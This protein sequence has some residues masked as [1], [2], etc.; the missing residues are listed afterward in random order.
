[1]RMPRQLYDM[2]VFIDGVSMMGENKSVTLP[3]LAEKL[4]EWQGAGMIAPV[5]LALGLEKLVLGHKYG[6]DIPQIERTFGDP[7]LD[8]AQIRFAGAFKNG[9]GYDDVQVVV[10]GR[11]TE[12]DRG[13]QSKGEKTEVSYQTT[14]VYYKQTRNG[15]VEFEIDKENAVFIVHGVDRMAEVRAIIG[16]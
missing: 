12:L 1:M 2:N 14:C 15:F 16:R 9:D 4:E 8:A 11:T 13:D 5:D 3:K 10:R 7:R 6:G